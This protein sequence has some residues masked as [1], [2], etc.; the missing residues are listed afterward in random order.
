MSSSHLE[1]LSARYGSHYKW[2]ATCTA[3]V[4]TM[5][6]SMSSTIVNVA[7]P[8]IMADFGISYASVQWVSTAFL[9]SMTVGMLVNAWCVDRFGL[10]RTYLVAL[11]AYL[12]ASLAGG[13]APTFETLVAARA[14]QGIT[15]GLVQP[16]ALLIIY[17]VFPVQERG[18]AIGVYGMGVIL[19]PT[20]GPLVGGAMV[21]WINWRAVFFIIMPVVVVAGFMARRYLARPGDELRRRSLDVPGLLLLAAWITALLWAITNGPRLGWHDVQVLAAATIGVVLLLVFV[22]FERGRPA[23]LMTLAVFRYPGFA[24]AFVLALLTGAGLFSLV[25]LLPLQ[26]QT[27]QGFSSTTAGLLM[28]PAG[29]AMS[30]VYPGIGRMADR[31]DV[32]WL[33]GIGLVLTALSCVLLGWYVESELFWLLAFWAIVSRIGVAFLMP[34]VVVGA[35]KMLPAS[36]I[37]Q[38]AGIISFARQFG[39]ALGIALASVLLQQS[40]PLLPGTAVVDPHALAYRDAYWVFALLFVLGW[41]PAVAMRR[42]FRAAPPA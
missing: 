4:G 10:R 1:A 30:L 18:A 24:A 9:A 7:L 14:L 6:M 27:I 15:A 2:L 35:L 29:L 23:P 8:D 28:M 41:L 13:L 39:G 12:V 40:Q 32:L 3:M 34:P 25:Y 36:L 26:V 17:Q 42:G 5:A 33:V 21:D 31:Y 20:V 19:G 38:G 37:N 22:L 16:L 11:L